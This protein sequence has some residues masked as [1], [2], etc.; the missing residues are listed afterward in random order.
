MFSICV[1]IPVYNHEHAIGQV[2]AEVRRQHYPCILVNDGS[3]DACR[4]VLESLVADDEVILVNLAQKGAAVSAGL[5][6]AL[7]RGFTHAIQID[8][9]G[10]HDLQDLA[11]FANTAREYPNHL[12]SGFPRYDDS[13]PR[14]RLY[15]RYLTHVWVWINTLSLQIKDSMCGFR[16]YPLAR[17]VP[18]L[19]S[20]HLGQRM[21]F[22]PEILVQAHWQGIPMR[23]LETRV[24]YPLDGV[25]H[26]DAWR[27][28]VLISKM[29]A[30][31][32]FLM[33]VRIPRILARRLR[34]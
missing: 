9:D 15:G 18:L 20:R 26:F 1:V 3:S 27:D 14:S 25:S 21:D 33:L 5:R 2:V 22:D 23:W 29:H 13:I 17:I 34:A 30:K 7:R 24:T 10:Q 16:A 6:E 11:R 31:L 4:V 32:F 12:V 28:N 19:D 8:A